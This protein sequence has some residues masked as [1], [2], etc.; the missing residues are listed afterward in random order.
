MVQITSSA[1]HVETRAENFRG[2]ADVS[3]LAADGRYRYA[4]GSFSSYSDAVVHRKK[5]ETLYP[6]AFVIAVRNNKIVP[7]LEALDS[8]NQTKQNSK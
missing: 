7:L 5:I 2:I 8:M 1:A 4:S 6:D 3:E